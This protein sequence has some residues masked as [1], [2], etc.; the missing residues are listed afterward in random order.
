MA[1]S[2]V[3]GDKAGVL[4]QYRILGRLQHTIEAAQ[5]HHRQ[6][7]QPVLRRAIRSAQ[8]V[9]DLPDFARDFLVAIS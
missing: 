6:H 7:H 5:H 8:T 2:G 1:F 9:G 3:R 4:G